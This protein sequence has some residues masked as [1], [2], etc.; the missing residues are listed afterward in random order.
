VASGY[1]IAVEQ[2][3][4]GD[5]A[6]ELA[7]VAHM[8]VVDARGL[9][10]VHCA[11]VLVTARQW[12]RDVLVRNASPGTPIAGWVLGGAS[13]VQWISHPALAKADV[14]RPPSVNDATALRLLG[15][16]RDPK[17]HDGVLEDAFRTDLALSYELLKLVNNAAVAGR[18]VWSIG[19]AIRLLGRD[20]IH[21]RLATIVLRSLGDRGTRAELAHRS[22]VRGRFCELLA[23]DAGLARARGPLFAVGFLSIL[24]DL[25]GIPVAK[26]GDYV[27]LAPDVRDAIVSRADFFGMILS[28]VEAYESERWDGVLV[29]CEAEGIPPEHLAD[30]YLSSVMWAREQLGPQRAQAAA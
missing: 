26:L 19:H 18:E 9:G 15:S 28:L 16:L 4:V 10:P 3:L 6:S 20:I 27:P 12:G 14:P 5:I 13:S 17:V 2:P 25:L 11:Q 30:R 22:L 24:P 7:A 29:R 23:D 1:R 21:Q 8:I